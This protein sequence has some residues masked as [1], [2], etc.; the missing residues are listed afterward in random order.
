MKYIVYIIN[1]IALALIMWRFF[2]TNSDKSII[3]LIV[4]YPLLIALNLTVAG[5]LKLLKIEAYK[6]F[7]SV[8][9]LLLALFIPV[10]LICRIF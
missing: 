2:A 7:T 6:Y 8:C 3:I 10:F 5:I 4:F 1:I 9:L